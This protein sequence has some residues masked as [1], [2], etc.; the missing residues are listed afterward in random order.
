MRTQGTVNM[1]HTR[2]GKILEKENEGEGGGN[3]C[4]LYGLYDWKQRIF[5]WHIKPYQ[6]VHPTFRYG[7]AG[8]RAEHSV[9]VRKNICR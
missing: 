3:I 4:V 1:K 2:V 9:M 7:S 8:Y 6:N 5:G